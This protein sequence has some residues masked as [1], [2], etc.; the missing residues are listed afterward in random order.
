MDIFYL[1][2]IAAG[3]YRS[4]DQIINDPEKWPTADDFDTLYDDHR[5]L[6]HET[7]WKDYYSQDFLAQPSSA[8]FY[9]LPNLQDLPESDD[10]LGMS[11]HKGKSCS[12]NHATKLPRWA[13]TVAKTHLRQPTLSKTTVI[14]LALS[15]LQATIARLQKD[16]D[17][18]QDHPHVQPYP[19]TQARFWLNRAWIDPD[20]AHIAWALGNHAVLTAQGWFDMWAWQPHYSRE[21]W[22]SLEARVTFLEPNLDGTEKS[23][24]YCYGWPDG[25]VGVQAVQRGWQLEL[26]SDEEIAFLAAVAVR[27]TEGVRL[28]ELD[29][30]TRSHMLLGVLSAAF[31]AEAERG[32]RVEE[33][34]RRFVEAGRLDKDN[35]EPW[36]RE[37]TAVMEPYVGSCNGWPSNESARSTLLRQVLMEN[38]QLFGRWKV[39]SKEFSFE[40][41]P[42]P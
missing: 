13:N 31:E 22:E 12:H 19:E 27:E 39:Y 42:R 20:A 1:A 25:G 15:T 28:D 32:P 2:Q 8:R 30:A 41:K 3:A 9:R 38:G 36:I 21:R 14:D 18:D 40:L 33:L 29:Y 16:Q 24:P 37:A 34:K 5:Q 17:Q 7:V 35:T 11:R 10:A 23:V 6:L 26:G 4:I